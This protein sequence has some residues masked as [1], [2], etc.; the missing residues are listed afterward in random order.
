MKT[1]ILY[2]TST[3]RR[4][5]PT[6]QLFYIVSN[7]SD[8]YEAVVV[9][10]SPEPEDSRLADFQSAG[11]RVISLN[12]S[13]FTGLFFAKKALAS[14]VKQEKPEAIHSQGLRGDI[15]A[16]SFSPNIPTTCTIRNFPQL[17]FPM[18]YG[19]ILGKFMTYRQENLLPKF[20]IVCGVSDAVK[21][22]L[23][24]EFAITNVTTV[25]NGV[26]R[27]RF[28][29]CSNEKR[30]MLR[31]ELGISNG[32]K[33]WITSLGK[34]KRK[35]SV[36]V[37]RAF[38]EYFSQHNDHRLLVIGNGEQREE[39]EQIA[40]D[41]SQFHFYGKV[42]NVQDYLNSSDYFVSASRAEGMPN[43]VLEAMSC[44]LP[45]VLSD[46]S[47]HKEIAKLNSNGSYIFNTDSYSSLLNTLNQIDVDNHQLQSE[48]TVKSIENHFDS[49]YMSVI[50]QDIYGRI[51]KNEK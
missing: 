33:I 15:L 22:N 27:E 51:V 5:G 48:Y 23:I 25:R 3:L 37:I 44:G 36:T 47:P 40:A 12:M 43:A 2:I 30:Q 28:S 14:I 50:Y 9:T 17:D 11:I 38:K 1:K 19:K 46:I 41:S 42:K 20:N 31:E 29:I 35:N 45:V 16:A 26:D 4:T 18:T 13:R 39:C 6:S 34:D 21:L 8:K 32:S 24:N 7:L 49:K 10:L